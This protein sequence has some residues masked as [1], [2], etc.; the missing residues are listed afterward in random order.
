MWVQ[1]FRGINLSLAHMAVIF[2]QARWYS[3]TKQS[4]FIST[5]F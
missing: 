2:I 3:Y 5:D 1:T 4:L